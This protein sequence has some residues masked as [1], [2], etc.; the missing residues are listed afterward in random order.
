MASIEHRLRGIR[1][2]NYILAQRWYSSDGRFGE[3]PKLH[4]RDV[5][6]EVLADLCDEFRRELFAKAGKQDPARASTTSE[7]ES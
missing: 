7:N 6:A 1:V 3:D 5:P 4:V 2:P